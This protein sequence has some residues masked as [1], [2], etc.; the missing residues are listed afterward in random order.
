MRSFFFFELKHLHHHQLLLRLLATSSSHVC[1]LHVLVACSLAS[2][3]FCLLL[4][5]HLLAT[6]LLH[7]AYLLVAHCLLL[8]PSFVVPTFACFLISSIVTYLLPCLGLGTKHLFHCFTT[9]LFALSFK[10]SLRL[11]I[12]PLPVCARDRT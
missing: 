10:L 11:D 12:F 7:V 1:I 2:H 4:A 8:L 6:Y 3:L 5:C 9:C